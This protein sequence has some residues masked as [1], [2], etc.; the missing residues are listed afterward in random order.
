MNQVQKKPALDPFISYFE[1]ITKT[2]GGHKIPFSKFMDA[3][4][5]GR[6]K[7]QIQAIRNEGD[8]GKQK[9]LKSGLPYV[10]VSGTFKTRSEK[11]I[12]VYSTLIAIDIDNLVGLKG[13]L[14]KHGNVRAMDEVDEV[15]KALKSDEHTYA[16]FKS[17]RGRGLCVVVVG[18][19]SEDH[20]GHYRWAES[21]YKK[22]LGLTIDKACKDL[23][24]PRYGSWDP[25]AYMDFRPTLAGY[26]PEATP[27]AVP[28]PVQAPE[29]AT[30]VGNEKK[31]GLL[32]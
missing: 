23:S 26:E 22:G 4:L 24:R 2:T 1:K 6:W 20:L 7:D 10:T 14:D 19:K 29:R 18:S 12:D 5:S 25:N 17:A 9:A 16:V 13:D 8:E 15:Q 30:P 27:K 11:G 28:T 31:T 3:V 32:A 21:Y